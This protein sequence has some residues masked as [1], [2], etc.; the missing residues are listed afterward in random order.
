MQL[1]LD[2]HALLWWLSDDRRLGLKARNFI[3]DP[4]HD[5]L[6]SAASM[7]GIAIKIPVGKLSAD[8]GE[9]LRAVDQQGFKAWLGTP[10]TATSS[11]TS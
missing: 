8:V 6:V 5:V 4:D 2:T 7:W 3:A 10:I 1:L 9:I 11:I